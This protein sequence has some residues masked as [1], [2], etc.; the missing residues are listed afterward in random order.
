MTS[1]VAHSHDSAGSSSLK[2]IW[3]LASSV[4]STAMSV[5]VFT[6]HSTRSCM[7]NKDTKRNMRTMEKIP[8]RYVPSASSLG[9]FA[10]RSTLLSAPPTPSRPEAPTVKPLPVDVLRR[11]IGIAT[12]SL[13]S[14]ACV[15][16]SRASR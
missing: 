8:P 15:S 10:Y 4:W 2:F 3:N 11:S 9:I 14:R 7:P 16:R 12:S 1:T 5:L 6:V 13:H